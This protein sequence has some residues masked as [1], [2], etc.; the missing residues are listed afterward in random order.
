MVERACREAETLFYTLMLYLGAIFTLLSPGTFIWTLFGERKGR[1]RLLHRDLI[2]DAET[3]IRE[4]KSFQPLDQFTNALSPF[5]PLFLV[6]NQRQWK[7]R[8][9]LFTFGNALINERIEQIDFDGVLGEEKGNVLWPLFRQIFAYSFHLVFNRPITDD[10]FQRIYPGLVDINKL[11]KR[12]SSK[13]NDE[14]RKNFYDEVLRLIERNEDGFLFHQHD[15]FSRLAEIDRVSS[16]GEDFLTTMSVQ[17]TDLLCHLL[18][19]Y[20]DHPDEFHSNFDHCFNET[21][22]LYPLTDLWVRQS[23]DKKRNWIASLVQLNRNGWTQPNDFV[24]SRWATEGHPPLL[25]WG[26]DIRR[27]PAQQI[28]TKLC[29]RIFADLIR[30]DGFWVVKAENFVHERTFPYGCQL[31]LGHGPK[32]P[33]A[34]RWT[35][36]HQFR[37]KCKRWINEKIRMI[38]Q[39]E[40]N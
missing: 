36:P 17:C 37:L 31:W 40:L 8:R 24:P 23:K 22:R 2:C 16:V 13:P 29:K 27:C 38:D 19:L 10:E 28:G 14:E 25:S 9:D 35:F 21:L 18:V 26:F 32:P 6:D 3:L 7:Q 11:L 12:I 39:N 15:D 20:A 4:G 34:A 30:S 33:H 1:V 5:V